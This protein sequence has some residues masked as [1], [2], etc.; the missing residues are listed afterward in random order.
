MFYCEFSFFVVITT[1][2]HII[3]TY[4]APIAAALKYMIQ[5]WCHHC[6]V[7]AQVIVLR[8]AFICFSFFVLKWK[9]TRQSSSEV[10]GLWFTE[11]SAHVTDS[12]TAILR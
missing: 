6:F 4:D 9:K 10:I 3:S 11:E 2:Y 12:A 5:L 1:T 7:G 8:F